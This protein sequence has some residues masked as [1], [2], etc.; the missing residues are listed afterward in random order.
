MKSSVRS[1][2][3]HYLIMMVVAFLCA[4]G[5]SFADEK[6]LKQIIIKP[7]VLTDITKKHPQLSEQSI[8]KF[9][10]VMAK[11]KIVDAFRYQTMFG[12]QYHPQYTYNDLSTSLIFRFIVEELV[13]Q[14]LKR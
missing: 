12:F 8:Q 14:K 4:H 7:I 5:P 13:Q 3:V 10:S 11:R 6:D 9:K 1:K 2:F